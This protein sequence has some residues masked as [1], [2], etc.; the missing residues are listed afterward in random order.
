MLTRAAD[1][2]TGFGKAKSKDGKIVA[3]VAEGFAPVIR[4]FVEAQLKP[5]VQRIAELEF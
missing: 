2:P 4:E 3:A 5:L 1:L